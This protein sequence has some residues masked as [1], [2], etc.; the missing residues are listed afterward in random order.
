MDSS[1]QVVNNF[2]KRNRPEIIVK[3]QK[4]DRSVPKYLKDAGGYGQHK[5]W[6]LTGNTIINQDLLRYRAKIIVNN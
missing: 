1:S 6:S 2:G 3:Y 5:V 4:V